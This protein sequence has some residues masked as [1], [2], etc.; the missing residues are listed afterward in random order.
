[1]PNESI[2]ILYHRRGSDDL[3]KETV[4]GEKAISWV[5]LS[6]LESLLIPLFMTSPALSRM[7]GLYCDSWLSK[8]RICKTIKMLEI[9]EEE[10]L[11][12][13]DSFRSFN[14]FFI[15]KLKM[16][17]RPFDSASN[18]LVSPSDCRIIVYPTLSRDMILPIKGIEYSVD[19]LLTEECPE[20]YNGAVAVLRL[21]PSDYH[22]FHFPCDGNV[23]DPLEIPGTYHSVNPIALDRGIDV[24]CSNKRC[25][26]F[27]Q[28]DK[29]GKIAIIEVGAF[30]VGA[31]VQTSHDRKVK[32]MQE[33]GYFKFGGST[34]VLLFEENKIE[35]SDDLILNSKNGYETLVKVGDT[36]AYSCP[37]Q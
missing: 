24:F 36:L 12:S 13:T 28:T 21:N 8:R 1:M 19:T 20:Y 22:R 5:Y 2:E 15:R 9:N 4:L 7:L 35:I 32:K 34:I 25:R 14:D 18:V 3:H 23:S 16:E 10:F 33:K 26:T 17:C 30:G 29:F 6:R 31:I 11:E 27:L 37:E